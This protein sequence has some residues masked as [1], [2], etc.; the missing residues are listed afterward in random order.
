MVA[1][2]KKGLFQC[3]DYEEVDDPPSI[4]GYWDKDFISLVMEL[5]GCSYG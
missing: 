4:N 3:F 1:L 5:F 2:N